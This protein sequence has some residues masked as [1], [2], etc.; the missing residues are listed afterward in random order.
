M[1]FPDMSA[2]KF[3]PLG[4]LGSEQQFHPLA[5]EATL[6]IPIHFHPLT[7]THGSWIL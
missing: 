3:Y 6:G 4:T 7:L 5:H 1:S 2:H